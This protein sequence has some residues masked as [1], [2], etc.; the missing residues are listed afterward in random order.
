MPT[1]TDLP[2]Q[3]G[4]YRIVRKLG[5]GG[6][7]AVYLA[8]DTQLG[9]RV[10]VK[11]PHFSDGD[12]PKIIERFYREAR[13]AAGIEHAHI[14]RV[15]DVGQIDGIH[16]LTM[17]YLEGTPLSQRVI[18]DQPWPPREAL[19][20]IRQLAAAVQVLHERGVMHR[21]L[22][23][24]NI[25]LKASGEPVLMD[26]GLARGFGDEDRLTAT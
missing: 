2:T 20:L 15:Y 16:Y 10:A 1:R 7:G 22:K 18:R 19:D 6:M 8:D 21:D 24:A 26:F 17:E 23:P 25:F 13:V 3:F 9:R 11:V 4:R 12:G 5:E 14:C